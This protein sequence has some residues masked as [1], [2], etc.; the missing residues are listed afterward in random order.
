MGPG[1]DP[2]NLL[3]PNDPL[4]LLFSGRG[5]LL[6]RSFM[7]DVS[8]NEQGKKITMTKQLVAPAKN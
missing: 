8:W 5:I 1:F 3:D 6:I 2:S 4:A 7:N